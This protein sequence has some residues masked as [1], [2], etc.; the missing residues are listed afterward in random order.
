M[1][2]KSTI[3]DS[4]S[5]KPEDAAGLDLATLNLIERRRILGPSYRLFYRKPLHLVKGVGTRLF[6]TDGEEYLD[7]Y[8]NVVSVGHCHPRVV[9]A[10]S[11]QLATLNT[12]TRYLHEGIVDY[13]EDILSLLP[14]QIDRIMFMCSGSEANDLAIR[15]AQAYTGGTGI[16]VTS[17]A[18][19]GNTALVTKLS[20][21]IGADQPMDIAMRMIP[22]PD[23]YRQGTDDIGQ[24]LASQA[25]IQIAD[26]KRHGIKFAG[27]L[28]DSIFS[29]DGVFPGAPYLETNVDGSVGF[30]KP[31][32]DLVHAEGGVFIADEVQPGFARTGEAFWGFQRHGVQPDIVTMGKPMANGLPCSALAAREE[33]LDA[34]ALQSPYF[35]TFAG[36]PVSMAAAQAVLDVIREEH[37]QTHALEV[38]SLLKNEITAVALDNPCLGDVRGA[39]FFIGVEIVHPHTKKPD[40][41]QA[42]RIIEEMRER[43]VLVSVCGPFGNVIKVRPPLVFSEDDCDWF[44]DVFTKTLAAVK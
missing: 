16:L 4:N 21:A 32:I 37:V 19:H 40:Y 13:A 7:A 20:P 6:D 31:L 25:A 12:H 30:L 22:T 24:W 8:N 41:Q 3:M 35:N 10:A 33:V 34:F 15:I 29:S 1:V 26:M 18:Y 23:T 14:N 17:E 38:G 36:N 28:A 27:L 43:H 5:F 42:V 39:G 9:E 44:M 11:R 2:T